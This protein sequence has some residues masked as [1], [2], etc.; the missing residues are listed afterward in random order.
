MK[1]QRNAKTFLPLFIA[2]LCGGVWGLG[3]ARVLALELH[4]A[5]FLSSAGAAL[6]AVLGAS[7]AAGATYALALPA[8]ALLPLLLPA[9]DLLAGDFVPWRGPVLL[10]GG[11]ALTIANLAKVPNGETTSARFR[12]NLGTAIAVLLP[13]LIYLPDI[14][15]Y[16]GRAD[17]F[18]FQVVAP[19]LGIAHPSGYPLYILVGKLFSLLPFG[20]VAWRVNLSSA[21]C[22]ALAA[23]ML[24][25]TLARLD[26]DASQT[27]LAPLIAALTLAF[28]PTLWSRAIEAETYALNTLLV[29]LGLW[30][31]THWATREDITAR[32]LPAFGLLVGVGMA[33]HLTLGALGLLALPLLLTTKPR[34]QPRT[35]LAAAGLGLLGLALY[36]YIPLR[37]PAINGEWMT[38]ARFLRFVA[39]AESGGAL[40]PL[41]FWHDPARWALVGERL[42]AQVSWSGLMLAVVGLLTLARRRWPLALGTTL[43]FAAWVWFNLSF[44][45]ADPDYS[46]FLIPAHVVLIFW[47]GAGI[48]SLLARH[49][50]FESSPATGNTLHLVLLPLIALLPLSRLW[51]TGPTLDTLSQGCAD[52][53]WGRYSLHQP[54]AEGAAILADSEK[55][56]PLYYLQ[57]IE[58]LRPDLELV[59]LFNEAQYRADMEARL[60]AG[61]RVYLARYLPGLD[62]YGGVTSVGPLVE[63]APPAITP[64]ADGKPNFAA[65]LRLHDHTLEADPEG[66]ALHHLTLTW[67]AV[68]A[69]DADLT[70]RLRLRNPHNAKIVWERE[71]T[72]P[73]NGY[74]T[75]EAWRAGQIVR[76]YH[77]L[78]WPA[79]L[80]SGEYELEMAIAPRFAEAGAA[81]WRP[82][83]RVTVPAQPAA[84]LPRRVGAHFTPPQSP[85]SGGGGSIWLESA[86]V[87]GEVW[88]EAPLAI[89][90]TW[91]GETETSGQPS[92]TWQPQE[93]ARWFP[94]VMLGAQGHTT[95]TSAAQTRRYEVEA[96]SPPGRYKLYIAWH[97]ETGAPV[98]ARCAWLGAQKTMCLLA[99]VNVG[100][101]NA[102]LANFDQRILLVDADLDASAV[103]AGGQLAVDLRWRALREMAHDYT[104]FVQVIGPDGQL[105]GQVDSWPVQGA[106]PT[107][108]WRGGEEIDDRYHFYIAPDAPPGEHQV[109]VGWYR[110]ADMRRLPVRNQAG[111]IIGDFYTIGTFEIPEP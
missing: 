102:G 51:I 108:Q 1:A 3:A 59:T 63:V 95:S 20:S 52:E 12:I 68:T 105:Y 98:P 22:A 7:L 17:T 8:L 70:I 107:S 104:V 67:E 47:M 29:A 84:D 64:P 92:L 97:A 73:V 25:R 72:R 69:P 99:E 100:P 111:Q 33:S 32:V 56:P 55:F 37:W 78:A 26:G 30:L 106:S 23:G 50:R 11:L 41:A 13:L 40:H 110:L 44:Y 77:A 39:N 65:A 38:P 86:D 31:A 96:P 34:P 85:P 42:L 14:S 74:T 36:L 18:E 71:A 109:I 48:E 10:G 58:G 4:S 79:W 93:N 16:V 57:Q 6:T 9:V 49:A 87:P 101:S 28:S 82:L 88:A 83:T 54:L 19:R 61:Q 80:P 43:A 66:R 2:A 45:V 53:A 24:Y 60:S 62:G 94:P 91:R 76:D 103:P 46:A 27:T 35:L 75:T 89:D 81:S 5:F 90:L 15:P 21:V